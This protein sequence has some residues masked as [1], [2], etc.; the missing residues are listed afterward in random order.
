MVDTGGREDQYSARRQQSVP[1]D[2]LFIYLFYM[3]KIS[4]SLTL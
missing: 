1:M 3:F 4:H 2:R